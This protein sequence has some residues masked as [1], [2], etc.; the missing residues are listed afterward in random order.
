MN[1]FVVVAYNSFQQIIYIS[2]TSPILWAEN[3]KEAKVFYSFNNA[4]NELEDNI[5]PLSAVVKY[6]NIN[7]IYI[8]EYKNNIEVGRR[9][10]L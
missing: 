1:G 2:N 5:V 4:K 3:I 7:S 10:F 6:T 9:Q 8:L